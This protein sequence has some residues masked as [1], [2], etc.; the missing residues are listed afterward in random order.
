MHQMI[1]QAPHYAGRIAIPSPEVTTLM[2]EALDVKPADNVL[3]IGTG[4]G[5]QTFR[6]HATG[7]KVSSIELRPQFLPVDEFNGVSLRVGDGTKGLPE[8]SPYSVILAGCGVQDIPDAWVEQLAE[9][10]RLCCPV[11]DATVQRLVL[12]VKEG[13]GLRPI[14]TLAYVR[15]MMMETYKSKPVKPVYK[16]DNAYS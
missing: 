15:F 11:G 6:L 8:N 4:S 3:E 13:Y 5:Y 9:G 7:A 12:F 16:A 2:L 14:K 1:T 10:G